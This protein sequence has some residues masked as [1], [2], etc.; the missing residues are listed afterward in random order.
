MLKRKM[1]NIGQTKQYISNVF[2]L[3]KEEITTSTLNP[4]NRWEMIDNYSSFNLTV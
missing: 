4:Q 1:Q 2:N 3:Q